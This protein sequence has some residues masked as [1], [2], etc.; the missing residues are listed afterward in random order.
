VLEQ[1][2]GWHHETEHL[3][4]NRAGGEGV[5]GDLSRPRACAV[6]DLVREKLCLRRGRSDD[7]VI[8][9]VHG[10]DGIARGKIH[11]AI[12]RS[13][14]RGCG[15]GARIDTALL[16][17]HGVGLAVFRGEFRFQ[18]DGV[19]AQEMRGFQRMFF[20]REENCSL[21]PQVD[22]HARFDFQFVDEL[23]IHLRAGGSERLKCRGSFEGTVDQHAARGVRGFAARFS[24]LDH[25]DAGTAL[26]QRDGEREADN[27]STDDD[28]V[29]S[30][31]AA[32]LKEFA[33]GSGRHFGD[34]GE[35]VTSLATLHRMSAM[36]K[37]ILGGVALALFTSTIL[38]VAQ[39]DKD[40]EPTSWIY[41]SVLKDDNGKPV[42]NASVIMHSVSTDGKQGR[43]GMELKT[44]P[45]GKAD[46]DG[47]PYGMLRVQVLAHGFQTYGEDFDIKQAKTEITIKLKRPQGQFSV[48]D[49]HPKDT[50]DAPKQDAPPP[51]SK[52]PN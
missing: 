12:F 15:E 36:N 42:R 46:F 26:A 25:K 16:E 44:S 4:L 7:M 14:E 22:F 31:H 45:D 18:L 52:K 19:N 43:G 37:L 24:A 35:Q 21:V 3:S 47:I 17:V 6:D 5:W 9:D 40:N 8:G 23:R 32:I 34:D 1:G 51:D 10:G 28:Y 49:D 13:L 38:A 33:S 29:P 2:A 48:Y 30:L 11:A 50:S 20:G 27:A 41:F 39:K